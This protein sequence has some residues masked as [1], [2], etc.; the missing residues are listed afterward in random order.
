MTFTIRN[1]TPEDR[2]F[3]L[4]LNEKDVDVLSPMD[5]DKLKF[6]ENISEI[7]WILEEEGAPRGFL[8]A[9]GSG[10]DY[11]NENYAF[12]SN[13]YENFIYIDRIVIDEP[14]RGKGGGKTLYG[15]LKKYAKEKGISV[16]T[17]EVE[18]EPIYNEDSINF[19]KAMGFTE[20]GTG[21]IRGGEL[22]VSYLGY[23]E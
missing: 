17:A 9:I 11:P 22:H 14:F 1:F 21:R 20:V 12:F 8:N 23:R 19:H 15:E 4:E 7:F 13:K 3:V 10:A 18:T 16:I 5:L 6:Y 2:D